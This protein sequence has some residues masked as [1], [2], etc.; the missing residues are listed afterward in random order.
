MN[1]LEFGDGKIDYMGYVYNLGLQHN[2]G[3]TFIKSL[4]IDLSYIRQLRRFLPNP[5]EK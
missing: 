1:I 5:W 2:M 4:E 3:F